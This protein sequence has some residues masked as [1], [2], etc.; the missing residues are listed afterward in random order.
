MITKRVFMAMALKLL[1]IVLFAQLDSG[2]LNAT[3]ETIIVRATISSQNGSRRLSGTAGF[4]SV[5]G[6]HFELSAV[7]TDSLGRAYFPLRKANYVRQMVIQAFP[8]A[9]TTYH[10]D[11][12]QL[13]IAIGSDSTGKGLVENS[14]LFIHDTM[15]FYGMADRVYRL[16]NYTRFPTMQEVLTEFIPEVRARRQRSHYLITVLNMPYSIFFNGQPL[17]LVDGLPARADRMMEMDPLKVERIEVVA[18]RYY[19]G[20][21]K[22]DGIVSLRTYGG[23]LGGYVLDG[24]AR[25]ADIPASK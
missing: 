11:L 18:R 24:D 22:F 21:L 23:D 2:S 9:D 6:K 3:D 8:A 13:L 4:L 19:F 5:P 25:V 16:D 14:R 12:L 17:L 1:P 10:I 20:A 15:P 7:I